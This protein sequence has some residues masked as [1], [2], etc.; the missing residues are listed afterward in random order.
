M[1]DAAKLSHTIQHVV[2]HLIR[3]EYAAVE[4]LTAGQRL[5]AG[6]IARAIT[7]YGRQLVSPPADE[8][9]RSVVEIES[10]SPERWN[11]YVDL[12]TA[13]EGRSDLTL[14]LTVTDS[15]HPM[16]EVQ[17]DDIHVL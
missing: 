3:G 7:D 17:V 12:W 9:P 16:Y 8:R 10:S 14:E 11:V 6:E 4:A 13:E 1:I 5:N 15:T 2:D